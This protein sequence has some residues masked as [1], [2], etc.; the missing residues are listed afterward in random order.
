MVRS[1]CSA[2]VAPARL[3]VCLHLLVLLC[4]PAL[5]GTDLSLLPQPV[6][7]AYIVVDAEPCTVRLTVTRRYPKPA[8]FLIRAFDPDER[9]TFWKYVQSSDPDT[10][11]AMH[12]HDSI[13]LRPP[14]GQVSE[15][16]TLFETTLHL[17]TPG[18]HQVRIS[19]AGREIAVELDMDRDV[20]YGLCFQNG[21]ALPW[22]D[23]PSIL[24][25]YVPPHAEEL[26]LRGGPV[27]VRDDIGSV[28]ARHLTAKAGETRVPIRQTDTVWQFEFP[29]PVGWSL[30]A[31]GMPVV[32]CSSEDAAR[33]IRAS[34]EVLDDGTVVCHKFQRRIAELLP[35]ILSPE[36]VGR[37]EDLISSLAARR[38]AWLADPL[39]NVTLTQAF[40]PMIQHW[41]ERQNLDPDS[42][43]GGSL[44]GWQDKVSAGPPEN[45]W[46]RFRVSSGLWAGASS[47]YGAAAEHLALA[48]LH[49]APVNPYCG[50]RE[51]LW[52]AAAAA[53]RDLMTLQED[54]TWPGIADT[55][56]YP[57]GM[58][59][60]LAQKNLP[61]YRRA[62]PHLPDEIRA[63][64]T[65][66]LRHIVDRSYPDQ[67]VTCRNQSSHYL[68]AFQAF[69][70]GSEDSLYAD[71][72]RLYV[73]RWIAGQHPSGYHM[74]CIGP[75]SSYIGMTHWHEAVYYRTSEA[76]AILDSLRR[77]YHLFNHT[78]APEPDGRMLGG[79]NFNHR[80][81]EGFYFEQWGGGKGIIDDVLPEIGI[82]AEPEP[83]EEDHATKRQQAIDRINKYL[84]KPTL[85]RYPDHATWRY[86]HFRQPDRT[87]IFPC[88]EEESFIRLIGEEFVAVKRPSYY[89]VCYVGKPAGSYY[90]RQREK[91]RLPYADDGESTGASL[92]DHKKITP[93]VGGGLSGV[94]TPSYGHALMAANWSPTTHHGIT[95]TDENGKRWWE[96]YHAHKHELDSAAATL[97]FTGRV[98]GKPISYRRRYTFGDD[99]L[100][101]DLRL[102]IEEDLHLAG[103]VENIP[104]ARGG[105]KSRGAEITAGDRRARS[106]QIASA[107]RTRP[108]RVWMWCSIARGSSGWRPTA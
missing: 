34:V 101:V 39:R 6:V 36:R 107:L 16:D 64:W 69:A 75:D 46:D 49:D 106:Q 80:V 77:S 55:D 76:P 17:A 58:A 100:G 35:E 31:A 78:V 41:L 81:G 5:A 61:V 23:Q 66:G 14:E 104:L 102:D 8:R 52:R 108:A 90:I 22:P 18:V 3:C 82:W 11:G 24:H 4:V 63:V 30:R 72:A 96:D 93:F 73:Q 47:H 92:A 97:T 88:L 1:H 42:H 38:D 44:D 53:L 45:R 94:W 70:D 57:G 86:L 15:G 37:T 54:E 32:L 56:P 13:E 7:A 20:P 85:P 40:L 83:S 87:G 98:E 103:L 28:V 79:F 105:W 67:L 29:D 26:W 2:Q 65:D 71:L 50:K 62:A 48:A 10:H 59:F 95:A 91:L 27:I 68:V 9:L 21:D 89:A 84:D 99:A 43:W 51:L 19:T 60:P 12:L 33:E 74:E 25:V